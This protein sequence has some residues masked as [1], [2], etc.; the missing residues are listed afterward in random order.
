[1]IQI[2]VIGRNGEIPEPLAEIAREVGRLIAKKGWLLVCGGRSG[3]MEAACRGAKEAGGMTVGILPEIDR[4]TANDWVD[5]HICTGI[6]FARNSCVVATGDGVIAIGGS[7]GTLSELAY[8]CSYGK[9]VFT[10]SSWNAVSGDGTPLPVVACNTPEEAV[11][12][13]TEALREHQH[14]HRGR[15]P[16]A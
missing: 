7:T 4:S 13:L 8:A 1:M 3:V 2:A 12:R 11:E 10:L 5:I 9:P 16:N 6:G 15:C 14:P